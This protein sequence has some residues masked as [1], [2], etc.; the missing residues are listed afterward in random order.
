MA[1]VAWKQKRLPAGDP[2]SIRENERVRSAALSRR[3]FVKLTLGALVASVAL[4]VVGVI[5]GYLAPRSS[6]QGG[7]TV[8]AGAVADIPCGSVRAFPEA[9]FFLIRTKEGGFLAVY[10]R[11][12][13]L[14]C[15]VVWEEEH[16]IFFCPCHAARFDAVGDFSR[17]PSP[18]ALDLFP[19][20]FRDGMVLVD[21]S[22][23]ITREHYDADQLA[24]PTEE[25]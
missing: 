21:T 16:D 23:P 3:G 14:G 8:E 22:R 7:G 2:D 10:R 25:A 17:P 19:V 1:T 5:I 24:H 6:S 12:P 13:H 4:E 18:R 11:C 20:E 15:T 9:G